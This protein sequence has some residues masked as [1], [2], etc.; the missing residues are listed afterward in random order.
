MADRSDRRALHVGID[1]RELVGQPTGVGRFLAHILQAW[2]A[3][4]TLDH[5]FTLFLP[6]S[7]PSWL[8]SLGHR[9]STVIDP[10]AAGTWWEQVRLPRLVASAGV[11]ALLA[12]GYTAPL[13]VRCPSIVVIHDV[14]FFAHPEW[15][16]WREGARRR[17]LTAASARRAAAIVTVSDFSANEIAR[18]IGAPRDR[19][20]VVRHGAPPVSGAPAGARPPLVL[21]VGSL[22]NRRNL[23][24]TLEAFAGVV[25]HLSEARLILVGDNRTRPRQEPLALAERLGLGGRVEWRAYVPD[26]ELDRLYDRARVFVFLSEYEGFALTPLEALAHGVPPLLLDTPVAHE[27]YG[28][29]ACYVP[30][31]PGRIAASMLALLTDDARHARLREAGTRLLARYSWPRAAGEL[32]EV[33]ESVAETKPEPKSLKPEVRSPESG[34][35]VD[36]VIVNHNTRNEL[37][38]CL[39]SIRAHPLRRPWGVIVVD[40]ASN[41]GSPDAICA[42]FPDVQVLA[43]ERNVGFA[44][45]NNVA[46]RASHAPLVLLLNSDT[47][48]REGALDLLID[49]LE[50]TGAVAAGPRLVNGAGRPEISFGDMLSPVAELTQRLRQR[51]AASDGRWARRYVARRVARERM[52]DWVS[53]ACLLVRR[54][55]AVAAGLFDERY[56]LYEED[57]DFCAALRARGGQ[58]LFTPHAEIVH[59]RGRSRR[60]TGTR[61]DAA[62]DRSHVAFYEKHAPRWV[63]LLRWWLRVRGR[64]Q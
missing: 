9:F 2:A 41:D 31:D 55:A 36:I 53:G 39:A 3:D 7:G 10:A 48:V 15:F 5:R 1:A 54:E 26:A 45:A 57:V 35:P 17:W 25:S 30:A 46:L 14:S 49:R 4:A 38:A 64:G 43:L 11:D 8:D 23:P 6:A 20:R 12:P 40:N 29:A 28:E 50:A 16:H 62:Y 59:L 44:A 34:A 56:F 27:V 37:L 58:I 32:L 47:L 33:I 22:F 13:R 60:N 61:A 19:I 24:V 63:P 42:Q 18:W 52:V 21:F 51:A